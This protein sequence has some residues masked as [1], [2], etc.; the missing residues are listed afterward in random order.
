MRSM[1]G[2]RVAD[3]E[4]LVFRVRHKRLNV[5]DALEEMIRECQKDTIGACFG[6]Q[7][8]NMLCSR[9]CCAGNLILP[10]I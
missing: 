2:G 7:F 1:Q 4:N 10:R 5:A 3:L 6:S 9:T 8:R